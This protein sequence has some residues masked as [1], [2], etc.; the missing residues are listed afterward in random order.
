MEHL[1]ILVVDD[2]PDLLEMLALR[3]ERAGFL[4]SRA[5]DPFE[6][7]ALAKT[8]RHH[9]ILLDVSM[10]GMDGWEFC[11]RSRAEIASPPPVLMMTAWQSSDLAHR[12][13]A[14][15]ASGIVIKPFDEKEVVVAVGALAEAAHG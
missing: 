6:G 10:P 1:R 7:L 15:G 11:R 2:E 3:L 14:A 13:H 12:A 8:I 4:V 9:A 5:T